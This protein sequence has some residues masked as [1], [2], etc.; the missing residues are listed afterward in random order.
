MVQARVPGSNL[1]EQV[2]TCVGE[3]ERMRLVEEAERMVEAV[4]NQLRKA[5]DKCSGLW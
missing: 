1:R 3:I 5:G 4:A 2:D